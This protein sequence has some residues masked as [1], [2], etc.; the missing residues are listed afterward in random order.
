LVTFEQQRDRQR[1]YRDDGKQR[2]FQ[3]ARPRNRDARNNGG[4]EHDTADPKSPRR[5]TALVKRDV[6]RLRD[7]VATQQSRQALKTDPAHASP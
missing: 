5:G 7:V 1:Q 6:V 2:T 4:C 3:P